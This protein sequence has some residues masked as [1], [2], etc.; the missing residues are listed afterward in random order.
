MAG[1]A[2]GYVEAPTLAIVGGH[3]PQVLEM[4]RQAL[5]KMHAEKSLEVS[6]GAS[7][8]FEEPGALEKV[9][10]LA[11]TWFAEELG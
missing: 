4:N 9:A 2:L 8:L 5:A 6:P 1:S 11:R 10:K 3:D 7:H